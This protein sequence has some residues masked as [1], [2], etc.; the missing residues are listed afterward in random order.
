MKYLKWLGLASLN[1]LL[2]LIGKILAPVMVLW[3]D[4]KAILK[5]PLNI[6][7]GQFDGDLDEGFRAGHTTS[8]WRWVNRFRWLQRNSAYNFA[9]WV[10][11]QKWDRSYNTPVDSINTPTL[12]YIRHDWPTGFGIYYHGRWGQL[13][14]GW[15]AFNVYWRTESWGSEWRVPICLSYSPFKRR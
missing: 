10:A 6:V 3:V 13:K 2:G 12:Q 8:R 1:L 7:W 4:D 15:K 11:G 5:W 9:Y 14:L